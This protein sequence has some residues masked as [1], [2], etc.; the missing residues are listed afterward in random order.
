MWWYCK[1]HDVCST[2]SFTQRD[3]TQEISPDSFTFHK[4]I[5][6]IITIIIASFIIGPVLVNVFLY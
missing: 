2:Y 3:K 4:F 6:I 1:G 5:I